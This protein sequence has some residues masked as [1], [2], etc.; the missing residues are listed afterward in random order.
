MTVAPVPSSDRMAGRT[1]VRL[2]KVTRRYGDHHAVADLDLD[3]Q[4]G[5]LMA[6]LGPSGA[7]KSTVLGLIAGFVEPSDG[8]VIVGGADVTHLPAH[9]RDIGVVFQ[10]YALFPHL[11]VLRNVMFPLKA[12]RWPT[13]RAR[14]QALE[15][16]DVVGLASQSARRP[17]TLSGG[18]QQR[19]ALARALVFQPSVL[20]L[21][22]PLAALDL[23]LREQ[24]RSEIR[25]LQHR[26]GTTTLLVTHDQDEAL[27]SPT[28]SCCW[29][30]AGRSSW[31]PRATS[32]SGRGPIARPSSSAPNLLPGRRARWAHGPAGGRGGPGHRRRAAPRYQRLGADP[33]GVPR[34]AASYER[35]RAGGRCRGRRRRV[36]RRDGDGEQPGS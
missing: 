5:E 29:S 23:Q 3:V 27:T 12:R 6:V 32:T 7:G 36:P 22:E 8:R 18:Q 21:D 34:H 17:A 14:A 26:L 11:D 16:L 35:S 24:M 33:P 25:A 30:T 15:A 9:R 28:G 4:P 1:G 31:A 20:L 19:V 13:E 10:N 2:E